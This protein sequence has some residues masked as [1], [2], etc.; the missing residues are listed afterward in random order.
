MGVMGVMGIMGV[1]GNIVFIRGAIADLVQKV[2]HVP[3]ISAVRHA[4]APD[5]IVLAP[6]WGLPQA[7]SYAGGS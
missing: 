2:H 3:S 6:L 5:S 7:T 1:M 4:Q